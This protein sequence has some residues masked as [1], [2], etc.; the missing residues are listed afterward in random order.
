M[1]GPLGRYCR[2]PPRASRGPLVALAAVLLVGNVG[3]VTASTR[4]PPRLGFETRTLN[5]SDNNQAH[6]RWGQAGTNYRRVGPAVYADGVSAMV[7]GPNSRYVSNRIFN[8]VGQNLFSENDVSQWGWAWGQFI[9]H[10]MGLRDETAAEHVPIAFDALDPLEAFTNDFGALDFARTPAAPNTGTVVPRQ[11]VNTITSYIDASNVYGSAATRLDWLRDGPVDGNPVNN[12][13]LLLLPDDYLPAVGA[14]GDA[15]TA[16][17]VDL[18]GRLMGTPEKARVAGD[19]RANENIALTAIH[20]MFAREHNRIVASLPSSL[21]EEAKFQIARRVVGA[22]VQYITYHEFLPAL[23]VRLPLYR[24]YDSRVNAGLSNEFAV[25]GYRAHSMIHGQFDVAYGEGAYSPEQLEAF[26]AQGIGV[27]EEDGESALNIPLSVAFGNPDLLPQVGLGAVLQSLSAERQYRNDEQIDN[28]LRSVLFQVPRPD[29]T[30]PA[31]CQVPVVDPLCFLGVADLGAL[32]VERGRDHGLPSYNA[33]RRAYGLDPRRSFTA[34][35]GEATD[36]FP[37]D[38]T[39]DSANAINDPNILDFVELRDADGN[40]LDPEDPETQESAVSGDRRTTLAARLRA[41]YGSVN[42]IDAFVGMVSEPHVRGSEF[43]ALQLAIWKTQFAALRDGD[44]YFYANDGALA[45]IKRAYGVNFRHTLAELVQL[46]SGA[47]VPA[48]VFTVVEIPE[49]A[50]PALAAP[51]VPNA[52]PSTESPDSIPTT[53][54]PAEST[55]VAPP[56]ESPPV[57]TPSTTSEPVTVPST[58]VPETTTSPPVPAT[59]VPEPTTSPP[60][61]PTSAPAPP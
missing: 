53:S 43:G 40:V 50:A 61:P 41:I 38:P 48:D 49:E 47:V 28:T 57:T 44:R 32:D 5:G 24:G 21:P 3:L 15:A 35:T 33:L 59:S 26:Q 14:R 39:I 46:N 36:Q 27:G 4:T 29:T 54:I 25:V 60:S 2:V 13:A 51:A 6:A 58:S 18:M 55:T 34:I 22:E 45:S 19:V 23:G 42:N 17:A 1:D 16:P 7:A 12:S 56:P 52:A 8:D 30:D 10:D 20:T 9:D 31:A 11:Q 37:D